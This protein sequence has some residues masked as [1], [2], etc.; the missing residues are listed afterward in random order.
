MKSLISKI[1]AVIALIISIFS[2]YYY[3]LSF[4]RYEADEWLMSVIIAMFSMLFFFI[5]AV[6]CFV[7]AVKKNDAKFNYILTLLLL[8]AIPMVVVFGGDGKD[9]FNVIWNVYY[10]LIFVLEV[11]SIKKAWDTMRAKRLQ[12][13]KSAE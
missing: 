3:I 8:G 9:Y 2:F 6:I 10:L 7:K 13:K 12:A 4:F 1:P 5:D 11:I